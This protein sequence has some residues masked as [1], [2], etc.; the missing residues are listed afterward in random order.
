MRQLKYAV[1][2]NNVVICCVDDNVYIPELF[3]NVLVVTQ[4]AKD[5]A[6]SAS[7]QI[8]N[9]VGYEIGYSI[10]F[11]NVVSNNTHIKYVNP[12]MMIWE[13]LID[14]MLNSYKTIIVENCQNRN[15]WIDVAIA[16][17]AKIISIR[18]GKLKLVIQ[19]INESIQ[20]FKNYFPNA[21]V[22]DKTERIENDVEYLN[23]PVKD[24]ITE[25]IKTVEMIC[26]REAM[27]DISVIV[28]SNKEVEQVVRVLSKSINAS[29]VK[30][31]ER[32]SHNS[33]NVIVSTR[34]VKNDYVVDCGF[35]RL[36]W[37]DRGAISH[38][39]TAIS[40]LEH[41]I[42]RQS[43]VRKLY[44][45]Y[46]TDT[47]SELADYPIPQIQGYD[48]TEILLLLTALKIDLKEFRF[49]TPPSMSSIAL[50][51][52]KL[53]MLDA[54]EADADEHEKDI[55]ITKQGKIMAELPLNIN[56]S[57]CIS[58]SASISNECFE[59]VL[60]IISM[61]YT[62]GIE[63][64]L[65]YPLGQRQQ[66]I[67]YHEKLISRHG[68]HF[69][70]LNIYNCKSQYVD[71]NLISKAKRIRRQLVA[72]AIRLGISISDT[73]PTNRNTA[74]FSTTTNQNHDGVKSI[75]QCLALGFGFQ[76]AKRSS[77]DFQTYQLY[78]NNQGQMAQLH[79]S[80]GYHNHTIEKELRETPVSPWVVYDS[81]ITINGQF[82]IKNVSIIGR[83]MLDSRLYQLA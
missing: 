49:I 43:A 45:L 60:S 75:Q 8:S 80:S 12:Q 19:T 48:V 44:C 51:F 35:V 83:E 24:Y 37:L 39:T 36:E 52:N 47:L 3:D 31:F 2:R 5:S 81:L 7:E 74:T 55:R 32:L 70:L 13:A 73:S 33:R 79:S 56:Q 26:N 72:Y 6:V 66:A 63:Q 77:N 68:D 59:S 41:C 62:G 22:V 46:T 57:K 1:E 11:E 10:P 29:V 40:K 53:R 20:I 25:A 65:K 21:T 71:Q 23:K 16:V 69:T 64:F 82:Y 42:R 58:V 30:D 27:G 14:P 50:G 61:V 76:L 54:V 15:A 78:G 4:D 18:K 34:V 28:T 9:R 17:I 38:K 67:K